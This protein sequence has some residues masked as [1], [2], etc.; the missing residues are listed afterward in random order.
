MVRNF[1]FLIFLD[2]DASK[3]INKPVQDKTHNMTCV[4]SEDSDQPVHR[5]V[6]SESLLI[7][8]AF[9]SLQAIQR[10]IN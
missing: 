10:E 7:V 2:K 3:N 8:C 6:W 5:P 1:F 9:Y 4:T